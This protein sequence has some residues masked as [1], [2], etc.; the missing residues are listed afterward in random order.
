[1]NKNLFNGFKCLLEFISASTFAVLLAHS[2]SSLSHHLFTACSLP[3]S[4]IYPKVH[5]FIHRH[6]H[7]ACHLLSS[8]SS[9]HVS[10]LRTCIFM[11]FYQ[12]DQE[13]CPPLEEFSNHEPDAALNHTTSCPTQLHNNFESTQHPVNPPPLNPTPFSPPASTQAPTHVVDLLDSDCDALD[14]SPGI[15]S[16]SSL[17]RDLKPNSKSKNQPNITQLKPFPSSK[18][19]K[20]ST[21]SAVTSQLT[22]P[23]SS[24]YTPQNCVEVIDLADD[25]DGDDDNDD[26]G[27]DTRRSTNPASKKSRTNKT[28]NQ[29]STVLSPSISQSQQSN[30]NVK[31]NKRDSKDKS[32]TKQSKIDEDLFFI[33][34]QSVPTSHSAKSSSPQ[35]NFSFNT[36]QLSLAN[37]QLLSTLTNS[38][39]LYITSFF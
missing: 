31:S 30:S 26:N 12:T 22:S 2:N 18:D 23:A 21:R 34:S 38:C 4:P 29:Q 33:Q 25:D 10:S 15:H 1:M 13:I 32:K 28:T 36:N 9:T 20:P 39:T 17:G 7:P 6:T 35:I 27:D 19:L 8:L 16:R 3:S 5:F 37:D 11:S 14:G 24:S